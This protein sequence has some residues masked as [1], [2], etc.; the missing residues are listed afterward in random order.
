MGRVRGDRQLVVGLL[1][2]L[3]AMF[4]V[5]GCSEKA[6]GTRYPNSAP[7]T[8]ISKGP[9]ESTPNYYLVDVFW[10]GTDLDGDVD[11]YDVAVVRDIRR[12]RPVVLDSLGWRPT[13][14][15]DSTFMVPADSCCYGEPGDD[16]P[17]YAVSYWG[18][19]VRS[20]DNDR[21]V[22]ET[23]ASVFFLSSN[24]IPR[25]SITAPRY[26][27]GE[28]GLCSRPYFEWEGT[29][30]DG[31]K[32]QLEYKYLAL[33][34]SMRDDL[35][36]GGLP[37]YEYEGNGGGS[38]AP[39][40]GTWSEWVPADC[41]YVNDIDLTEYADGSPAQEYVLLA[42]TVKD[43]GEAVLPV[44]LFDTY[45]DGENVRSFL[46]DSYE[47]SVPARIESDR[48][49]VVS[50]YECAG[51]PDAAPV[52]FSG[53]GLYMRFYAAEDRSRSRMASAYRYY[54]D[55]PDNPMSNWGQWTDVGPLRDPGA[56]PEWEAVWPA[57]GPRFVPDVGQ[58]VFRV[59]LRDRV[60]D[61]TC[62]Q[63]HFDVL[64]GPAGR[65]PN[66]LLV[67]DDR[68][69]WYAGG[70]IPDYEDREFQMWSD[71]LE[72]Y[73]WQEWDTG[74]DFDQ[75]VPAS[76]V[77]TATTVIWSVDEGAEAT[78]DLLDLCANRGNHLYSYVEAGG[79]LIVIGRSPVYCTMYWYDRT[80]D[81][82]ARAGVTHI[83][84]PPRELDD[85]R[86]FGHFMWDIFGIRWMRL[87][88]DPEPD[89]VTGMEPCAGYGAWNTVTVRPEGEIEGW[90]GYFTGAFVA[91][92]LRPGDDVHPFYG[93]RLLEN[94][95]DPDT[96]WVEEVD[97]Y[98]IA[99]VY[100]EGSDERGWAAYINLPAW[101]FDHGQIR[102][103]IRG[104]L[105]MFG[106]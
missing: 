82:A 40:I 96:A 69:R 38:A 66:I 53:T 51:R 89:Y 30:P 34:H 59:E 17:Y 22:D 92:S 93:V 77:G 24:E 50:G 63:F 45:N 1:A 105:E 46:V 95:T 61:T 19:F 15:N 42:V 26:A 81:P 49:G 6:G 37:P 31:D 43:E 75:P 32:T 57:A 70:S 9:S 3:A 55:E 56:E 106:E 60:Q 18:I 83:E 13:R 88:Y 74:H 47:C 25:V 54:F 85:T 98:K 73:D 21:A 100:V 78:P 97:C 35:W 72:G 71:I 91:T 102:A 11:H 101:W 16:D 27:I 7:D 86:S 5:Q 41:T 103:M 28:W 65:D 68:G 84:F 90:P 10:Y 48:L 36:G 99:A 94:P 29:D 62:A 23:P 64:E 33:P 12:G 67:D 104:L 80:P 20:V 4:A 76:L 14:T 8:H 39:E 52:I 2:V 79:N 87:D 44:E 58:H